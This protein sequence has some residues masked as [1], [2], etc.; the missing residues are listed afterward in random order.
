MIQFLWSPLIT[1]SCMWRSL[2]KGS[3][4]HGW[5]QIFCH[6][7]QLT[8]M[9]L[10]PPPPRHCSCCSLTG[11]GHSVS[12]EKKDAKPLIKNQTSP[13]DTDWWENWGGGALYYINYSED[14]WPPSPA[15]PPDCGGH[16]RHVDVFLT[17][18]CFHFCSGIF[19]WIT[20][21]FLTG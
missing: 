10:T 11:S 5:V 12:E 20:V 19:A 18:P 14:S 6:G 7:H 4:A 2:V 3:N 9:R 8:W 1:R 16:H 15:P 21:N 13:T 17:Q